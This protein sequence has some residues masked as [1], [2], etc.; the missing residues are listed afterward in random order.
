M[1]QLA[2]H[3]SSTNTLALWTL[4]LRRRA[5]GS[6]MASASFRTA[7]VSTSK[8]L[9]QQGAFVRML[10]PLLLPH[11]HVADLALDMLTLG[12]TVQVLCSLAGMRRVWQIDAPQAMLALTLAAGSAALLASV[13]VAA[14]IGQVQQTALAYSGSSYA[15]R[16]SLLPAYQNVHSAARMLMPRKAGVDVSATL[17]PQSP[18]SMPGN[19]SGVDTSS[20][21]DLPDCTN[22]SG[23]QARGVAMEAGQPLWS[24]ADNTTAADHF[25]H[26]LV[27]IQAIC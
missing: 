12:H 17:Q 27:R 2:V 15:A 6:Y 10:R 3:S 24:R 9:T 20:D 5:A 8:L 25:A 4:T 21:S 1:L 7:P 19:R 22:L 14:D 18:G 26:A 23:Q 16:R 13:V 11:E